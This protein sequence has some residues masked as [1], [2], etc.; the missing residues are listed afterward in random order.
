L[1]WYGR[2]L[3][4]SGEESL[5]SLKVLIADSMQGGW[6]ADSISAAV[7]IPAA[8]VRI[9]EGNDGAQLGFVLARRIADLLEID[10]V[11]VRAEH[12]RRGI[13]RSLLDEL[14]EDETQA[15]LAEA[16]LEL[17]AS[18]D[19][20]LA[21]YESLGFMVVGRRTRYY[22]DGDDALLLSRIT[23]TG[24]SVPPP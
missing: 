10:L 11:G 3:I 24:R 21:L 23:L 14:I 6:S 5:E 16:R 12:R 4:P 17:A 1:E 13:A 22:P 15:G 18:N 19:P 9:A 2:S 20:A 7:G 8:R